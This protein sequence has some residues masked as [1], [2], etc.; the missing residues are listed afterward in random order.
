[1]I[2]FYSFGVMKVATHIKGNSKV[3]PVLN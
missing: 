2:T 3:V 1:V